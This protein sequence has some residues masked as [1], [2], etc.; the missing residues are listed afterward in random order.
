MEICKAKFDILFPSFLNRS[1]VTFDPERPY[2]NGKGFTYAMYRV[3][4]Y[5]ADS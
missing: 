3:N 1:N 4:V 5:E 2:L